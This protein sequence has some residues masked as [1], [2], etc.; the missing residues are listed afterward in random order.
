MTAEQD[1]TI[2]VLDTHRLDVASLTAYLERHVAG[3]EP[4]VTVRQFRGGQSNPTY[5]LSTPSA[6]RPSSAGRRGSIGAAG[7]V[8]TAKSSAARRWWRSHQSSW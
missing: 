6:Q 7:P 3:F 5:L 2:D 4:P 1:D 8:G